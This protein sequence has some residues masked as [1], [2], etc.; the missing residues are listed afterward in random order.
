MMMS[1]DRFSRRALLTKLGA[2]AAML[3]LLNVSRIPAANAAGAAKRLI[4]MTW[5]NG[6]IPKDTFPQGEALVFG[7]VMEP[8]AA[9]KAKTILIA[10]LDIS[11]FVE[12]NQR[13]MGHFTYS[14]LFTG[15]GVGAG[16]RCSG[17]EEQ[18]SDGPSIDYVIGTELQKRAGL[19]ESQINLGC[20]TA[21]PRIGTTFRAAKQ[22]NACE[23]NPYKMFDRLFTGAA[24]PTGQMDTLRARRKSVLDFMGKDLES[25]SQRLGTDDRMKIGAH[26]ASIRELEGR[27]N[28]MTPAAGGGG[29]ACGAAKPTMIEYSKPANYVAHVKMQ[30]DLI[31][32]A[33]K[34][35]I[36]RVATLELTNAGESGFV[37]P[38]LGNSKDYHGI[39]HDQNGGSYALKLR[40]DQWYF[41]QVAY[42]A[43]Q[44]D[45]IKEPGGSA[46]DNSAIVVANCMQDGA[47][48]NVDG[49]PFVIVGSCG[50]VFKT[51]RLLK[52]G[53]W[54]GKTGNYWN[55]AS[56]VSH[57][58]LLASLCNAMDLP[59]QGFGD[60]RYGGTG[61]LPGLA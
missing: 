9:F 33:V 20:R 23:T 40:I 30:L 5:C 54:V 51:D 4:T 53:R 50:G 22:P 2:S 12:K 28:P 34:C 21:A 17:T 39:A 13:Y 19:R 49:L 15:M 16:T 6:L 10:G 3:P 18:T 24:L 52:V 8:L 42:L 26:L 36:T 47:G 7:K 48:H 45:D 1:R 35:D 29:G 57:C 31:A 27:L 43:K 41:E 56:G 37:P 61:T 11:P 46:L 59:V 32:L 44:L 25:F 38:W 55:G 60:M 58:K 14:T